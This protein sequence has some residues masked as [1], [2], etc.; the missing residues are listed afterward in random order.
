[1]GQDAQFWDGAAEKYAKSKIGDMEGYLYTL[2][3]TRSYLGLSDT[4]LEVGCGTGSTALELADAALSYRATDIS[5]GM[6]EIAR[7]KAAEK[8]L[9]NLQFD[10]ATVEDSLAKSAPVSRVC[11]FNI[12][13]L[14]PDMTAAISAAHK[15][16]EPGGLLITKTPCLRSAGLG[17]RIMVPIALPLLQMLGKAP[18]HVH[19]VTV[20]DYEALIESAGFEIIE[21][22]GNNGSTSHHYVVARKL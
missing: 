14:V 7:G 15:A 3:R 4:V 5:P 2:G 17:I 21:T 6:I 9:G 8:D 20:R 10:V 16:L 19:R 11:A 1:M 22:G 18:R 12:L 13:H